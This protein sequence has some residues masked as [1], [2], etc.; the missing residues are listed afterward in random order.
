MVIDATGDLDVAASAGAPFDDGA[1]I[2]TTVSRIGGVDTDATERF[3]F[4]DPERFSEVDRK[5]RRLVGGCWQYWR[6]K[7]PLPGIV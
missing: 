5:A 2:V 1:F 4:E 3:Q 6:L 7:T